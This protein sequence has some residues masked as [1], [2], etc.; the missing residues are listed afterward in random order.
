MSL[1]DKTLTLTYYTKMHKDEKE[2]IW[3]TLEGGAERNLGKAFEHITNEGSE[4]IPAGAFRIGNEVFKLRQH[5]DEEPD[6]TIE[7]PKPRVV[8]E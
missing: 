1:L 3:I 7:P 5:R 4:K 2:N 6:E 8:S